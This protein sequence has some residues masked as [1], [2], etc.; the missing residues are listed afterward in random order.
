MVCRTGTE[1]RHLSGRGQPAARQLPELLLWGESSLLVISIKPGPV[2]MCRA[3]HYCTT[4]LSLTAWQN[5]SP[6][7]LRESHTSTPGC[8]LSALPCDSSRNKCC[9]VTQIGWGFSCFLLL[10]SKSIQKQVPAVSYRWFGRISHDSMHAEG[11]RASWV[12]R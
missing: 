1:S 8:V 2:M 10:T 12:H 3:P 7:N 9:V 4:M 6:A 11:Y 5:F